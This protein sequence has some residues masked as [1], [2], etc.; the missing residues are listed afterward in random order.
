MDTI[1]SIMNSDFRVENIGKTMTESDR[2][3]KVGWVAV[4]IVKKAYG[5]TE[6]NKTILKRYRDCDRPTKV[7]NMEVFTK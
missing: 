5:V 3:Y 6:V 1:V 4:S 7:M 2:L